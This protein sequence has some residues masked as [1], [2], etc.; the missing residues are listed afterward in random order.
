MAT[1]HLGGMDMKPVHRSTPC[2]HGRARQV[3]RGA[4]TMAP[5]IVDVH[6]TVGLFVASIYTHHSC[7]GSLPAFH[8]LR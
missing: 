4:V 1:G 2:A 5:F 6:T 7:R 3:G 8:A